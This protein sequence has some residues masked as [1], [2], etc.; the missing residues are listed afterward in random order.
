MSAAS[1]KPVPVHKPDYRNL[2]SALEV[3]SR[4]RA[5]RNRCQ[6]SAENLQDDA[7]A[8]VH[9][10]FFVQPRQ[11]N[12]HGVRATAECPR[13]LVLALTLKDETSDLGLGQLVTFT[14]TVS[15]SGGSPFTTSPTGTSLFMPTA[16]TSAVR[17]SAGAAR[18]RSRPAACSS[19]A[20]LSASTTA[21][22]TSMPVLGRQSLKS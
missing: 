17:S 1:R 13:H 4:A 3:A 5:L 14:A 22:I 12:G 15:P 2:V 16:A 7:D 11:V 20:T 8:V 9:T 10:E 6:V 19:A 21:A 18:P